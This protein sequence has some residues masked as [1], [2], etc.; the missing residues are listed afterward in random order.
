M[1]FTVRNLCDIRRRG[2]FKGNDDKI[3]QRCPV[4]V[5]VE[6]KSPFKYPQLHVSC[7]GHDYHNAY[8]DGWEIELLGRIENN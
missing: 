8:E 1:V 2:I 5:H 6:I 7:N 3:L 4:N